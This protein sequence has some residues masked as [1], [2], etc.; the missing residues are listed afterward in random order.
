MPPRRWR[1]APST[2]R[3]TWRRSP[4]RHRTKPSVRLRWGESTTQ[5]SSAASPGR[6]PIRQP[7]WTRWCGSPTPASCSTSR[8]A[9]NT[10]KPG[11]PRSNGRWPTAA[12]LT[13]ASCSNRLATRAKSKSVAKRARAM[14]QAMDDEQA[15]RRV[16][17]E[18]W[19]QRVARI[20]ARVEAL[21]AAP[22]TADA[23]TQLADAEAEWGSVTG[24]GA[25]ELDSE[26]SARFGALVG[27]ARQEIERLER[28]E[29]ERRMETERQEA[30]AATRARICERV[31]QARG[32]EAAAEVEVARGEW[33]GL[34]LQSPLAAEDAALRARF[35]E[36]CCAGRRSAPAPRGAAAN[37]RPPPRPGD[38]RGGR[39]GSDR[40]VR[41]CLEGH[42]HRV[43]DIARAGGRRGRSGRSAL[44]CRRGRDDGA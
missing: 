26:T 20:V 39:G 34:A 10:R 23:A 40:N 35:E 42:R 24:D 28:E 43:A 12:A 1:S 5:S 7:L 9:L 27:Q 44:R 25:F 13:S 22:G 38:R 29:A 17:L 21:A 14:V 41:R 37:H 16:A 32:E 30:L 8:P 11:S 4:I 33:E 36:A 6:R 2:I 15:A 18:Q 31:E 3:S 19:Q